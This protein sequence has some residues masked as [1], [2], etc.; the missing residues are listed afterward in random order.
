MKE[1]INEIENNVRA[2]P[3]I[4]KSVDLENMIKSLDNERKRLE[5]E[6][7]IFS[8]PVSEQKDYILKFVKDLNA[9]NSEMENLLKQVSGETKRTEE[10]ALAVR[11]DQR[12]R[13]EKYNI[14]ANKKVELEAVLIQAGEEKNR[15]DS[16]IKDL[17]TKILRTTERISKLKNDKETRPEIELLKS[18]NEASA[19]T[20]TQLR[21]GLKER[22]REL[23]RLE[24]VEN[25]Y[26]SE[27]A[28]LS[29]NTTVYESKLIQLESVEKLKEQDELKSIE[30][31]ERIRSLQ[32]DIASKQ[33]ELE[34]RERALDQL[35]SQANGDPARAKLL[36]LQDKLSTI[37]A[38]IET[39]NN[40]IVEAKLIPEKQELMRLLSTLR[41]KNGTN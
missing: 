8:L 7:N 5:Q 24:D 1:E 29:Q 17:Q 32:A 23:K 38:E 41:G 11:A 26:I 3:N 21:N 39:L 22:N 35:R 27:I 36:A 25:A 33:G 4:R 10:I 40:R 14:V 2:N 13:C 28:S 6:L 16:L 9:R 18:E 20:V 37:N 15:L 30:L 19:F 34:E 12:D 31:E